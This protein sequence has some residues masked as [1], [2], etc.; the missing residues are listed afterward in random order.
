MR[1]GKHD[2]NQ[3]HLRLNAIGAVRGF[4]FFVVDA[5]GGG[6]HIYQNQAVFGLCQNVDAQQLRQSKAQSVL[7]GRFGWQ[8]SLHRVAWHGRDVI[9]MA[10]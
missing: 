1:G 2:W 10:I 6:V 5:L 9:I 4:Q 7:F 3:Q 8:S